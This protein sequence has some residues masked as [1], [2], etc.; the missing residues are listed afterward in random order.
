L[1]FES[2]NAKGRPL[3]QA[4]LIKNY[5]FMR[6]HLDEQNEVYT[7]YWHPMELRLGDKLTEYIRH[8][9]MMDGAIVKQNDVYH[10]LKERVDQNNAIDY[11]IKLSHTSFHYQNLIDPD[12]EP[13]N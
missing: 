7:Q 9:L 1:V 2:L 12:N 3:T 5:F 4:D 10:S 8:Y 13:D 11:L 6:I